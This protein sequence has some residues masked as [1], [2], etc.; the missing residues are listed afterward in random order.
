MRR[1]DR[2]LKDIK[3]IKEILNKSIVGRIATVNLKG[4][5][6]I[7]PVSFI[8]CDGAIYIH[9]AKEGEKIA[10]ILRGSPVCFEVDE[11]ISYVSA[12]GPACNASYLYRSV[13]IKGTAIL[14]EDPK[15]KSRILKEF[16][17]KYQPGGGYDDI[18]ET[19]LEK[20]AVIKILGKDMTGKENAG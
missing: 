17:E 10:D 5:P 13:I 1:K 6:V 7:K 16:M 14:L 20:T 2:E 4:F 12:I 9:S 18:S 11:P 15:E 19:I 8:H 3:S